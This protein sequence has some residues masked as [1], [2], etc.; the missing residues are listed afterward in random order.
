MAADAAKRGT[1]DVF[2][3]GREVVTAS[4]EPAPACAPSRTPHR[5]RTPP[6]PLA[7][8]ARRFR[9]Q[10]A[11]APVEDDGMLADRI[12]RVDLAAAEAGGHDLRIEP[13]MADAL[14]PDFRTQ[15]LGRSDID[16]V[17]A[18]F[19]IDGPDHHAI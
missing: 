15:R 10:R 1:S 9:Q 13:D 5:H 4:S 8:R 2:C 11:G 14:G 17:V 16:L 12:H 7:K 19:G 3:S 18:E 6:D